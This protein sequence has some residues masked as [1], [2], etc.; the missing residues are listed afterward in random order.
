MHA[1]ERAFCSTGFAGTTL[2]DVA[3]MAGVTRGAVYWHF[4][5]KQQ[6]LEC[7][8]QAAVLAFEDAFTAPPSCSPLQ[9]LAAT[10]E[11]FFHTVA[12]AQGAY[13]GGGLLFKWGEPGGAAIIRQERGALS[14]R[15]RAHA[16]R[17]LDLAVAS[18]LLPV[19]TNVLTVVLAYEAYVFGVLESW[20]FAPS[21]DL[22]GRARELAGRAICLVQG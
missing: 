11:A 8:C 20:L 4:E 9:A 3:R 15:L 1:A 14:A 7:V 10:A 21:F 16:G 17:C 18:Q 22:A 6:L 12:G 19:S 5:S 13:P 2:A